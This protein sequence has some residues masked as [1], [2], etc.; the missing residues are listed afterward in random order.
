MKLIYLFTFFISLLGL[1]QTNP[2]YDEVVAKKVGGDDYGMKTYIFC[3]LKTGKNTTAT[4]K[5]KKIYFDGHMKNIQKLADEGK[6]VV[7]GPFM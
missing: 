2:N 5:E 7:A 3:I 6:L 1:G 4:T